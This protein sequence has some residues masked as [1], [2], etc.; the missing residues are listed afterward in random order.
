MLRAINQSE[1]SKQGT[2]VPLN[3]I[4]SQQVWNS[5]TVRLHLLASPL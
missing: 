5:E 3:K 2:D 4:E 1:Q